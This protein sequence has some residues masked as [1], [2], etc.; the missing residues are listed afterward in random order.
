MIQLKMN[1]TTFESVWVFAYGSLIWNPGFEFRKVLVG[2]IKGYAR[3]F[4]Q[5]SDSHR[6]SPETLGRVATLI[7]TKNG[8]DNDSDEQTTWGLAFLIDDEETSMKY[9][10]QRESSIGG[11]TTI[12]TNFYPKEKKL[13]KFPVMVYMAMPENR[14]FLGPSSISKI[15][16]DIANAQ[17]YSGHNIE[18]LSKLIAFMKIELPN[19][20]DEHLESLELEVKTILKRENKSQLLAMFQDAIHSWLDNDLFSVNENDDFE[21]IE[22]LI[23][24]L[25]EHRFIDSIPDQYLRCMTKY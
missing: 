8:D 12:L 6:G 9:L 15:A 17:G 20:R 10:Q 5:G 11:Y 22:K 1:T 16:E 13:E 25:V 21:T 23:E 3:R 18:Y 14:L 19:I 4:Y 7:D 2:H 24:P